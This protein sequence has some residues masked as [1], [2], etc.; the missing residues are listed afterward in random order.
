MHPQYNAISHTAIFSWSSVLLVCHCVPSMCNVT[1][2]R[3]YRCRPVVVDDVGKGWPSRSGFPPYLHLATSEMWCWSGRRGT[4]RK[5]SLSCS[6]VY[7]YN[8]AQRYK[9]S[10]RSVN[11][12]GL[13][14]CL[15]QLSSEHLCV[16]GLHGAIYVLKNFFLHPSLYLLVS[17][18]WLDW[19][20]TWLTNHHPSVLRHCWLG[21]LTRKIVSEITYNVSSGTLNTTIPYHLEVVESGCGSGTSFS[22]SLIFR[23]WL[24]TIYTDS[25]GGAGAAALV[26]FVFSKHI[27][28]DILLF[29]TTSGINLWWICLV[30]HFS[31]NKWMILVMFLLLSFFGDKY[32][33]W[34]FAASCEIG[35]D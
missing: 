20:L 34:A 25:Q 15:V 35:S 1:R 33:V 21:H 14:S 4:Q 31:Y 6:I 19:P 7:Y 5:L 32:A 9:R 26:E 27:C 18:A 13:W 17:W 24:Y 28:L 30:L 2:E 12:I 23:D 29:A 16:F 11:C 22:L 10:Y 8:G 3:I